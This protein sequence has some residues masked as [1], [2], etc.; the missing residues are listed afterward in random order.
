[1]ATTPK[2]F[3]AALRKLEEAVQQLESGELSLDQALKVFS[4]GVKQA[5]ICQDAL[6]EVELKVNVLLKQNDG[7]TKLEVFDDE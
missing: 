4:T 1:M 3:E 2:G 7:S 6:R 5:E